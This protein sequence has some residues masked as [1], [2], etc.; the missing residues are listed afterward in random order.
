MVRSQ[1]GK[2]LSIAFS[3]YATAL[4]GLAIAADADAAGLLAGAAKVDITNVDAD[5]NVDRFGAT[6]RAVDWHSDGSFKAQLGV[7][8]MRHP[9][10]YAL[11]WP[12]RWESKLEPFDLFQ[13]GPL[14]FE[15]PD[16]ERFPCLG[17]AY[18]A[19]EA[20]GAA[21]A[22]LNAANEVACQA[23][24]DGRAEYGDIPRVIES[25][26]ERHSGEPAAD[27]TDLIVVDGASRRTAEQCLSRRQGQKTVKE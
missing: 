19:L 27:L 25:V 13:A 23:F 18:R 6:R 4:A 26:L 21:P 20:G 2:A 12:Q 1:P 10:Q 11:T 3:C 24:L 14:E 7:T 8:D 5:G 17:L 15:P 22:A 9:I 16:V